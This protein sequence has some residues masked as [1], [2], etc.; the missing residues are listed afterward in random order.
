MYTGVVYPPYAPDSIIHAT[1]R[2]II[3]A[4]VIRI[5]RNDIGFWVRGYGNEILTECGYEACKRAEYL[6]EHYNC[7]I[8]VSSSCRYLRKYFE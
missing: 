5:S 8:I 2:K 6:Q 7:R 4:S 1:V 3:D